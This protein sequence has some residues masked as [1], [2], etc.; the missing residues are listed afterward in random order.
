MGAPYLPLGTFLAKLTSMNS[1]FQ[2]TGL[3][4]VTVQ[5]SHSHY[6][7]QTADQMPYGVAGFLKKDMRK[8]KTTIL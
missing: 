8:W 5:D 3:W 1:G 4:S 7:T 6:A 2:T